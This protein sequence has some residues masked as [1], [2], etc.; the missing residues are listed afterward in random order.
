MADNIAT[1]RLLRSDRAV[2]HHEEHYRDD[3]SDHSN[4][5]DN[6]SNASIPSP[7]KQRDPLYVKIFYGFS[8]LC[9]IVALVSAAWGFRLVCLDVF[10]EYAQREEW[11]SYTKHPWG[12]LTPI[13]LLSINATWSAFNLYR[14]FHNTQ[15]RLWP[16]NTIYD[17]FLW[18]LLIAAGVINTIFALWDRRLCDGER[19]EGVTYGECDAV[20]LQLLV[21][22]LVA[23]NIGCLIAVV[24]FILLIGR[25]C[26]FKRHFDLDAEI[27]L[28]D[29]IVE[30]RT[31]VKE[32]ML[33]RRELEEENRKLEARLG[34]T[35]PEVPLDGDLPALPYERS[36]PP[37]P[38]EESVPQQT[39]EEEDLIDIRRS[40][41]DQ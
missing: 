10:D 31:R 25:C 7:T 14:A 6:L 40:E 1:A 39:R 26:T 19:R 28:R 13:I 37:L 12:M 2:G 34:Q 9:S 8:L 35:L 15:H 21:V 11:N 33:R 20:M 32:L 29:M 4:I 30:E 23:V 18:P 38:D 36:L 3:I 17:F 22:E 24:H 41:D 27:E 16:L 5:S